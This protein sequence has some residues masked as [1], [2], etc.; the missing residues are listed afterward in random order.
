MNLISV[1]TRADFQ[2]YLVRFPIRKIA[3]YFEN[4]DVLISTH[5]DL[6]TEGRSLI[7]QFYSSVDW[8]SETDNKKVLKIFED[9]L[10]D[11]SEEIQTEI[12]LGFLGSDKVII[13][14]WNRMIRG[15]EKD[16]YKYVNGKIVPSH[17]NEVE[18]N[19]EAIDLLDQDQ[20]NEHVRRINA[21]L[22]QDTALA[23][24]SMKDLIETVLKVILEKLAIDYDR[25]EDIPSLL[26][27]VQKGLKLL[28]A[29]VDHAARGEE[30]IRTLL[31]NLG[32]IAVRLAELR[33]LYGTGHGSGQTR[34]GLEL[35]HAKLAV[36]SGIALCTF[37]LDTL[38]S[39]LKE[40]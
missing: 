33:N 16:G 14:Q 3:V 25:K 11:A 30:I 37:L 10:E 34:N 32:Q 18:L 4:H 28:P 8:K 31:S 17:D 6:S 36:S 26:K 40:S 38:K 15:L 35:R 39:R 19:H 13:D 2:E 27:K 9:I 22:R 29:G 5:E 7:D 21:S 12:D 20:F 1:R 23:I 24:G